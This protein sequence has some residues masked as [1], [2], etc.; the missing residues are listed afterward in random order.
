MTKYIC[1]LRKNNKHNDTNNLFFIIFFLF[2]NNQTTEQKKIK[3]NNGFNHK[4]NDQILYTKIFY[5]KL[6]TISM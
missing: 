4:L 6:L 5:R 3:N 2:L 1:D